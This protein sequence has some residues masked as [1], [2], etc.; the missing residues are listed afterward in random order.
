MRIK[1]VTLGGFGKFRD[2]NLDLMPEF[3]LFSGLNE[4]GKTTIAEAIVA[5]L[6]GFSGARKE[7]YARYAPWD[8]P[9]NYRASILISVEDGQ[10][11]LIG[12]DFYNG[13]LEVFRSDGFRLE[14]VQ[15]SYLQHLIQT[16]LGV[17][18]PEIFEHAMVFRAKDISLLEQDTRSRISLSR[19]MG[20]DLTRAGGGASWGSACSILEK[21]LRER[22]EQVDQG[23]IVQRINELKERLEKEEQR[24]WRSLRMNNIL[25]DL[26]RSITESRANAET[27]RIQMESMKSLE[28]LE[29][30]RNQLNERVKQLEVEEERLQRLREETMRRLAA[31]STD[32]PMLSDEELARCEEILGR[33]SVIEVEKK[34]RIEQSSEAAKSLEM[35]EKEAENLR[36]KIKAIGD[37]NADKERQ[38]QIASLVF[39]LNEGQRV[40]LSTKQGDPGREKPSTGRLKNALWLISIIGAFGVSAVFVYDQ[41]SLIFMGSVSA[42]LL[43]IIGA[44]VASWRHRSRRKAQQQQIEE[45]A[46]REEEIRQIQAQLNQILEGKT[47]EEYQSENQLF[48]LYQNDLW[49]LENTI[50]QQRAM[51]NADDLHGLDEEARSL[52]DEIN[53][54]LARRNAFGSVAWREAIEQE[55]YLRKIKD[56]DNQENDPN[57]EDEIE[58]LRREKVALIQEVESITT[59]LNENES[60]LELQTMYEELIQKIRELE[61]ER[62]ALV[63]EGNILSE[64]SV[65][66]WELANQLAEEEKRLKAWVE[67]EAALQ[68]AIDELRACGGTSEEALAPKIEHRTG[69]ILT[70]L[71]KGHYSEIRLKTENNEFRVEV[72]SETKGQWIFPGSLST[73][74]QDQIYLAFRLALAETLTNAAGYILLL[75]DPFV[76]FDRERLK[77][78]LDVLKNISRN[79][80]VIWWT[81][82][83][84]SAQGLTG[85]EP[86]MLS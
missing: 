58:G 54:L 79:H 86:L 40:M 16:E 76:N 85:V 35:L 3:S 69:E 55:R 52:T 82:D 60:S 28:M 7:L 67:E 12:R 22:T 23:R 49:H 5:V 19:L 72:K 39:R 75:D 37:F 4:A 6:F 32:S 15:S 41:L 17:T 62:T 29:Q 45:M 33:I 2:F 36:T 27:L 11:Y 83:I 63:A 8:D 1:R 59:Q 48:R 38:A 14:A 34:Y 66:P 30:R 43:A 77:E 26:D 18:S 51:A 80:Q 81:K 68:L 65:D 21:R 74:T 44:S 57:W 31:T 10:E 42:E 13:R 9:K 64:S 56:Q 46:A 20:E 71:T 25:D 84:E 61:L 73:G 70:L 50:A 47:Y 53:S 24:F 78:T